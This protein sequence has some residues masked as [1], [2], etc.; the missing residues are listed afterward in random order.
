MIDLSHFP[1][2]TRKVYMAT[3]NIPS[4]KLSTYQFIAEAAGNPNAARA[5]GNILRANPYAPTIPCH[6]VIASDGRLSGYQGPNVM[7]KISLLQ[8]EGIAVR[9]K[10]SALEMRELIVRP[11]C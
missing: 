2:F 8:A 10:F 4:G 6:R 11:I 5:V 9:L 7:R 3:M 1:D